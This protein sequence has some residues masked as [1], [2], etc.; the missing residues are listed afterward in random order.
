[1]ANTISHATRTGLRDEIGRL[2]GL[3]DAGV[4]QSLTQLRQACRKIRDL[5]TGSVGE[6]WDEV[7]KALESRF[8]ETHKLL[9][10]LRDG[11]EKSHQENGHEVANAPQLDQAIEEL[12]ELKQGVLNDWPWSDQELPSVDRE[13]VAAS[14]AAFKRGEGERIENLIHRMG[15]GPAK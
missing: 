8:D 2:V 3:L 7:G 5:M 15:G 13:M 11:P 12:Q 14:R 1:M 6:D 10:D 4:P 9:T